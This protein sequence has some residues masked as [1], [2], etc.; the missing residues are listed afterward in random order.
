MGI[1]RELDKSKLPIKYQKLSLTP[2]VDGVSDSVYL[3]GD[4]F[5]L[6]VF[7][8]K[9]TRKIDNEVELLK[10]IKSLKIAH[11]V[12]RLTIEDKDA[13]I[14]KQ[15]QGDS[16]KEPTINEVA[17]IG[18]FLKEFHSHTKNITNNNEIFYSRERLETLIYQTGYAPLKK[19]F[20][21][22]ECNPKLDGVIHGD[23]FIDNA[24]FSKQLRTVALVLIF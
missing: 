8:T 5:V 20:K 4:I 11:I 21:T 13:I 24:V 12:E 14:Y 10:S 19:Y 23:L 3:L 7:E 1:K 18:T 15:I 9:S 6:K 16:L 2:T 17:Q 22:I